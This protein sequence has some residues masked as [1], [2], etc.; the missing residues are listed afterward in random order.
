MKKLFVS[1]SAVLL[2]SVVACKKEQTTEITTDGSDTLSVVK[3]T[4]VTTLS[5]DEAKLK[6]DQ[7]QADLD[8][9]IKKGDKDAEATARKAL[10]DAQSVWD[11]AKEATKET[12]QDVKEGFDKAVEKTDL[13]AKDAK[14]DL[15]K[16]TED[17]KNDAN[18]AAQDT[19]EATKKA[20]EDAKK[21]YNDV[22]DKAKAK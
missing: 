4:E 15:K 9:A 21:T 20:T 6:V 12:A 22:L 11:Q 1:T 14:Q 5:K 16:A 7:A 2:L 8:A 3:T 10:A 13:A 18:K 19:K 17:I